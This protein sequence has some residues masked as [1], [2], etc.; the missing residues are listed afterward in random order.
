MWLGWKENGVS[1]V[2]KGFA[3]S[4]I[5][6]CS[7]SFDGGSGEWNDLI[8][9]HTVSVYCLRIALVN[10]VL[11]LVQYSVFILFLY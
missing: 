4:M 3:H 7:L 1:Y 5:S 11:I 2:V 10:C 8:A 9:F 6:F